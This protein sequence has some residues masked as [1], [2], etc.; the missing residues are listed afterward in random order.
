M[1]AF[2]FKALFLL[3]ASS[4]FPFGLQA[5]PVPPP[6][7]SGDVISVALE[8]SS[9]AMVEVPESFVGFG[10][11]YSN[12]SGLVGRNPSRLNPHFAPFM[13]RLAQHQ[14]S[15]PLRFGGGSVSE[16]WY[17]PSNLTRP[18]G[19]E[20]ELTPGLLESVQ[21]V[22]ETTGS[23]GLF[24]IN[25]SIEV[26]T[27]FEDMANGV[28]DNINE[29]QILAFELGNE[30]NRY[31][32]N[33]RRPESYDF[34][35]MIVES[36]GFFTRF[37]TLVDTTRPIIGPTMTLFRSRIEDDPDW[38]LRLPEYIDALGTRV[39]A[40]SQNR[41]PTSDC[42]TNPNSVRFASV[43]NLLNDRSSIQQASLFTEFI[44]DANEAGLPFWIN[45]HNTASCGGTD[46]SSNT[47][48][49]ALWFL[50]ATFA[51]VA[52]GA[53]A[54]FVPFIR[55]GFY[56]PF[57]SVEDLS[58]QGS[59]SS[60]VFPMYY[61]MEMFAQ[62]AGNNRVLV[63]S[64]Q[65][66]NSNV[67]AWVT[68]DEDGFLYVLLV[69]K[70]LDD[71]GRA[72]VLLPGSTDVATAVRL[73][74]PS[75]DATSGITL[76]GLTWDGVNGPV[77]NGTPTSEMVTPDAEGI[78]ALELPAAS[79]ALVTIPPLDR[80]GLVLAR[81]VV[82]TVAQ[83]GQTLLL[84]GG[85]SLGENLSYQWEQVSGPSLDITSSGEQLAAA[86]FPVAGIYTFRLTVS[87]GVGDS[88]S[89]N[90]TVSIVEPSEAGVFSENRGAFAF[91]AEDFVTMTAG[92]G[93]FSDHEWVVDTHPE[94]SGGRFMRVTPSEGLRDREGTDAPALEFPLR[95]ETPG[96]WLVQVRMW[97]P[98]SSS[99]SLHIGF[100]APTTSPNGIRQREASWIWTGEVPNE[101]QA[102]VFVPE[103][104]EMIF[105]VW[106]REDGVWLDRIALTLDGAQ[107]FATIP[108]SPSVQ[109]GDPFELIA[110]LTL[111]PA[112][113]SF[114]SVAG[115]RYL[116]EGSAALSPGDW[117]IEGVEEASGVTSSL[118]L[119]DSLNSHETR[120][121]R[122]RELP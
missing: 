108:N 29:E 103:A 101:G 83:T 117:I 86:T 39:G 67:R 111:N 94:A 79:A 62:T 18:P 19:I 34:D 113:L 84:E 9:P 36:D 20:H 25:A 6:L 38:T 74:S 40:I 52:E 82:T 41:Y 48:A 109:A 116:I 68:R 112:V 95:F 78:Y 99:D 30:P 31:V 121:F 122:V 57:L 107:D 63:E 77:P 46:G 81:P 80:S 120:F 100:E 51:W 106:P 14:G 88:N 102:T 75:V 11:F 50:D 12:L 105:R 97:G 60:T 5:S 24:G 54:V 16:T 91:E 70:D 89:A 58:N 55:T 15:V 93:N 1:K 26:P 3:T 7:E 2:R 32:A 118:S 8:P 71:S 43:E 61:G 27:L 119:E 76:G 45:E 65:I 53:E 21:I 23:Q 47:F 72:R 90:V 104:G 35:E 115:R 44:A 59:W 69:N 42:T 114:N 96:L 4:W 13:Q 64:E 49:S 73:L 110:E 33:D 85:D 98:D 37:E 66:T 87:N 28:L 17:N 56:A 10:L 92:E 22:L